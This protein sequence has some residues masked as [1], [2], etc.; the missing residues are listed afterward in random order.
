MG[1]VTFGGCVC[2]INIDAVLE[3]ICTFFT[4]CFHGYK[5]KWRLASFVVVVEYGMK[6]KAAVCLLKKASSW[7]C[8]RQ[9]S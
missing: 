2:D 4:P 1:N 3:M 8:G 9:F 7:I 6:S 5:K